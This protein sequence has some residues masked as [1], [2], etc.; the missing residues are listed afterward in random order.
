MQFINKPISMLLKMYW[1]LYYK[2]YKI[3][4]LFITL[5]SCSARVS[6]K[7]AVLGALYEKE[8]KTSF[9]ALSRSV[10]QLLATRR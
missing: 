6:K 10:Q 7:I 8:C 9:D 4:S 5:N 3:G 1:S 2:E